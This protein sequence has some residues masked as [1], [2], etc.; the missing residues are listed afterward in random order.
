MI[1]TEKEKEWIKEI[2]GDDDILTSFL[3][4]FQVFIK[5]RSFILSLKRNHHLIKTL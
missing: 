2:E 5:R 4:K 1:A 3:H